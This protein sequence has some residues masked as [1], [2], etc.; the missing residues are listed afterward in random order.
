MKRRQKYYFLDYTDKVLIAKRIL[1]ILSKLKDENEVFVISS[2][3]IIYSLRWDSIKR[4]SIDATIRYIDIALDILHQLNIVQ[5]LKKEPENKEDSYKYTLKIISSNSNFDDLIQNS[6]FAP[7]EGRKQILSDKMKERYSTDL[8]IDYD[9]IISQLDVNCDYRE[10]IN[11]IMPT[12]IRLWKQSYCRMGNPNPYIMGF[13][14]ETYELLF[15]QIEEYP[16]DDIDTLSDSYIEER[17]VVAYGFSSKP[18]EGRN[19]NDYYMRGDDQ[20]KWAGNETDRGH[21]I[22][23][24]L[25][26]NIWANI[27]PQRRDINRGISEGKNYKAMENYLK[28]NEGLFCFSRPIYFDFYNRPYLLEYGYITKKF[29]LIMRVF[30]NV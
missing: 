24:S 2:D 29:E 5:L 28:N 3:S 20:R 19:K 9:N 18:K 21:F 1:N 11:I 7:I 22:A 4:H 26:G 27:F 25:G 30:E 23:H 10:Q 14:F 17:T 12:L 16:D 13:P 15:D 8:T 6:G